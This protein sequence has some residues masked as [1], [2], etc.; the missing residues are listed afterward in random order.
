MREVKPGMRA[1]VGPSTGSGTDLPH[2]HPIPGTNVGVL[3]T[4]HRFKARSG[5][6]SACFV[7]EPSAGPISS[8]KTAFPEDETAFRPI[9]S[10]KTA[11]PED[12]TGERGGG[13]PPIPYPRKSLSVMAQTQE[14]D[15]TF[16]AVSTMSMM[17]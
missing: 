14:S 4:E 17:V 13:K 8:S 6:E 7:A 3:V 15:Q 12:E 5:S 9:P 2:R 11:F 1:W 10:S 16:S